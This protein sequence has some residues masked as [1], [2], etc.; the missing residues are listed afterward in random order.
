[1]TS[2]FFRR[3]ATRLALVAV[4]LGLFLWALYALSDPLTPFA[5][6][7]A[8]AYFVNPLANGMERAFAR[9]LARGPA[10]LRSRVD[11]RMLAVAIL[12][13]VVL[14]AFAVIV[15]VVVPQV[16]AQVSETVA[17]LPDYVDRL[18]ARLEP[19]YERLHLRY[20][21]QVDLAQERLQATLR[22]ALPGLLSPVTHALGRAFSSVLSFVLTLLNL[23]IIPVFTVY[24]LYDMNHIREGTKELVPHRYRPYV[25][26][27]LGELDRLLSAFARGQITVAL[28]L[29]SF[30][31]IAL[32]LCG[33]PMG[34][35]VG[36]VIG[37]FNL[38]PFM[39]VIIGLPLGLL[40]SWLDDQSLARLVAVAAVFAFGQ[41]VEGNFVTPRVVG[42]SLGLHS[43][44]IMLA[45][46]VGGSLF[47]FVGMLLA[48]PVTAGLS[49]FWADLRAWY[50][51][52]EFFRGRPVGPAPL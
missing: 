8:L 26:S 24:L 36:F 2:A 43:I 34:L 47:G 5:V 33:V 30:Y 9:G 52:S 4:L 31:A 6:A 3:P 22:T 14:A 32:T 45:V 27:R 21:V 42:S 49:V 10:W 46:L 20:P 28:I 29:G 50:G 13:L 38:V 35:L 1:M 51:R 15:L 37:L 40:L 19:A 12:T 48:V 18:R 17:K 41:F 16:Y 39:S 7:L 25:F 11:P 23:V 44:V